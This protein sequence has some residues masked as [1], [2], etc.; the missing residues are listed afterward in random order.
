VDECEEFPLRRDSAPDE[1]VGR[2]YRAVGSWELH[3]TLRVYK[4]VAESED[5]RLVSTKILDVFENGKAEG[6]TYEPE[7][8]VCLFVPS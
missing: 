8:T 5:P 6:I 7:Y 4:F 3:F 1:A 2:R